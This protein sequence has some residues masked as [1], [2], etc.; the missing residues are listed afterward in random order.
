MIKKVLFVFLLAVILTAVFLAGSVLGSSPAAAANC[1]KNPTHHDCGGEKP[2]GGKPSDDHET[3]DGNGDL[4]GRRP[5]EVGNQRPDFPG[6][7]QSLC[8]PGYVN[9]EVDCVELE[10]TRE[11]TPEPTSEPSKSEKTVE[12][13]EIE[14]A[15]VTCPTG[16]CCQCSDEMTSM[17]VN[18]YDFLTSLGEKILT[19]GNYSPEE[20][21]AFVAAP[22]TWC[23][24]TE[25]EEA[26]L[27]YLKIRLAVLSMALGQ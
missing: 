7:G 12:V 2:G 4:Q 22:P 17:L 1:E 16:D 13:E 10:P 5:A 14:F 19:E 15:E 6:G 18:N 21:T 11:P 26:Y 3:E 23:T 8:P 25:V 27:G 24:S 20:L 9:G